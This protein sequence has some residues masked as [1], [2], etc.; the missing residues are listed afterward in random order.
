MCAS[1]YPLGLE[2]GRDKEELKKNIRDFAKFAGW[3]S[4]DRQRLIKAA[5]RVVIDNLVPNRVRVLLNLTDV[6]N[7]LDLAAVKRLFRM[8]KQ[9]FEVEMK[10]PKYCEID[11]LHYYMGLDPEVH[12]NI[13]KKCK[14]FDEIKWGFEKCIHT[15]IKTRNKILNLQMIFK[16]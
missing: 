11:R 6:K 13:R 8:N 10:D 7:D 16:K 9:Q 15:L 4:N 12:F 3:V 5:I 2:Q 14:E 1:N